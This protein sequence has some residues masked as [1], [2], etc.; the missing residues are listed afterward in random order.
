MG[1]GDRL[2]QQIDQRITDAVVRNTAGGQ[3][4]LHDASR[5]ERDGFV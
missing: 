2:A 1:L 5:G 4:K 3:K